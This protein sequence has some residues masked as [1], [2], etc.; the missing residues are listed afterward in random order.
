MVDEG[1]H[2]HQEIRD[3][4]YAYPAIIALSPPTSPMAA[5]LTVQD[6]RVGSN[7]TAAA[8]PLEVPGGLRPMNAIIVVP[9]HLPSPTPPHQNVIGRSFL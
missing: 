2:D 1:P 7:P 6:G 5:Q 9:G 4:E 3:A 8:F